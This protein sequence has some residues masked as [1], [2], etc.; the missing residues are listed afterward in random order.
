ML[1]EVVCKLPARCFRIQL[2]PLS[3]TSAWACYKRAKFSACPQ[4][5]ILAGDGSVL[6]AVRSHHLGPGLHPHLDMWHQSIVGRKS[7]FCLVHHEPLA[8]SPA[9]LH[10]VS[11]RPV[12]DTHHS[13]HG[14]VE[15]C[16]LQ[17]CLATLSTQ[18]QQSA[19]Q[20]SECWQAARPWTV[21]SGSSLPET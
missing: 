18:C 10:I 9:T 20:D 3:A 4:R 8:S 5:M 21:P 16:Q 19:T 13:H 14:H 2:K 12:E 17:Q 11:L 15:P 1:G 6:Q 7:N